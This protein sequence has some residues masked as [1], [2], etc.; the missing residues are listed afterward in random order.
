MAR[1]C[2]S[3]RRRGSVAESGQQLA[4]AGSVRQQTGFIGDLPHS[5]ALDLLRE[6]VFYL[7]ELPDARAPT[8]DLSP[9]RSL[10]ASTP[11]RIRVPT[12]GGSPALAPSQ[13]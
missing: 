11:N 4:G 2:R 12:F 10:P 5:A 7:G 1:F 6:G 3:P 13:A 9:S 8:I